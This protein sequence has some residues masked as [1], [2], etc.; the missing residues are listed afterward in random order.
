M[1]LKIQWMVQRVSMKKTPNSLV[2]NLPDY[3]VEDI[4]NASAEKISDEIDQI[5][6]TLTEQEL[7]EFAGVLN[8]KGPTAEVRIKALE[9]QADLLEI[10]KE[11]N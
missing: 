9:T 1:S 11:R 2:K 8:P 4:L 6:T 7:R 3:A 10:C 5:T